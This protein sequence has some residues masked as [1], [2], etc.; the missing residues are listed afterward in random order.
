MVIYSSI[1]LGKLVN[2]LGKSLKNSIDGVYAIQFMPNTCR[3][4][5]R[6]YYQLIDDSDSF[7]ELHLF[8]D[9]TT[10]QN[11]LR[12][13]ITEDTSDEQTIGQVIL[14]QEQATNLKLV[15][16]KVLNCIDKSIAKKFEKYDYLY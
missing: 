9:I 6:M 4:K 15:K 14:T 12:I 16:N 7:R 1:D 3:L 10:Y 11:K 13:N 5:M 8:I 2:K